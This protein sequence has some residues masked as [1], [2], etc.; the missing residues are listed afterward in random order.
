MP[1]AVTHILVPAI[2]IALFRDYFLKK[3]DKRKFPLHYV[4]IAALSGI[5]P[6][7][8]IAAFWILY[9]FGFT[10][11]QV[12]RT[13]L[14]TLFVPLFF[15]SL[16]I[17]FHSIK[18][19]E[20]GKHKLKLNIIFIIFAF[21]S[22]IHLLLDALLIGKIIPFYPFSTFTIG[23]DLINHLPSQLA[24][25]SLPTL[26]GALIIIYLIYLEYKHK[27]SDFI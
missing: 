18:F 10:I 13:F 17:V 1:Q 15:L 7:L 25:I 26:D 23:L 14:H 3:R 11:E 16:S 21:G 5:I 24:N 19:K 2:I 6:D 4:L 12:H 9:F 8:D 27:I 22:F 20:L